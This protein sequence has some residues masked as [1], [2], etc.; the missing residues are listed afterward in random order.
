MDQLLLPL[1]IQYVDVPTVQEAWSVIRKMQVRGAPLIAI[2]A[3]LGLAVGVH[4]KRAEFA[5]VENAAQFLQASIHY[6]RTSRPTAVNLFIAMD[7]LS[8]FVEQE[9]ENPNHSVNG[10]IDAFIRVAEKIYE[11]DIATNRAIGMNGAN[12]IRNLVGK[13]KIRVLTICNTG[14]LATAGYGTALGVVRALQEQGLLEHVYACETRPYNQGARLTAFEIVQDKLPGTLI[15]D[16]MA[17]ALIA[18]K[19]VDCV[20][21]GAD[22]IAGNG[23]TANKIGTYQLAITANY[24]HIPFFVAAP[25]TTLDLSMSSGAEIHIEERPGHELTTIFGQQ[26]APEQISVWNPA[27]DVTP[28]ALIRGIFTEL[29]VIEPEYLD[30]KGMSLNSDPVIPV[31]AF[32]RGHPSF[33]TFNKHLLAR[34]EKA[35]EPISMPVGYERMTEKKIAAYVLA[36]PK[37]AQ[38]LGFSAPS[39]E[40]PVDPNELKITEVGDGNLN[41]V[42]IIEGHQEKKIV[43]K[44][45]LPFVR[46]VGENWP[47]TLKRAFFENAALVEERKLSGSEF[48][49]EVYHFDQTRCLIVMRYIEPPHLI[50]RKLLIK[51]IKINTFAKDLGIFAAKTFFGNSLLALSGTEF[52]KKVAIWSENTAM[53]SLTEKVI[54]TDPYTQSPLNRHTKPFLDEYVQLIQSHSDLKLAVAH[55]KEL[56]LSK[57]QT[58]I[59]GDLHTGSVMV[60]EG[61]TFVIDPEFAF[62]GPMGFDLGALFANLYLSYFSYS[63]KEDPHEQSHH[64]HGNVGFGE[65]ILAQIVTL[66]STFRTTFLDLWQTSVNNKGGLGELYVSGVYDAEQLK[67]AQ[68]QYLWSVWKDTLGFTGCKMIRRIIGIAHVEDLESISDLATRSI[69]EK[70]AILFAKELILVAYEGDATLKSRQYTSF[71][72]LNDRLAR[73]LFAS[74]PSEGSLNLPF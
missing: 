69:A 48:V 5:E 46:C 74:K 32:L 28:C 26:I 36:N 4:H 63:V 1:E 21:V 38:L 10:F 68:E 40:E 47:L 57:T 52:R 31:A 17:S 64:S 7:E 18:T 16:S 60:K 19:G 6:L 54:F 37:L 56:F 50:L 14:S 24:H 71:E 33:S 65:W 45:A 9:R 43:V 29:G 13:D 66:Y 59:H 25:T 58:L 39:E 44:Q 34:I 53:C 2:T 20:V 11:D 55:F 70:R 8:A 27:F 72:E 15:T 51:G 42:Y 30:P 3:A 49:P 67:K 41:F 73:R 62:Y 12:K 61:S 35:V 23:D 22:R